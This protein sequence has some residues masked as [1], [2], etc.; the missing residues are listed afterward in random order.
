MY[1]EIIKIGCLVIQKKE[2]KLVVLFL[3]LLKLA[4][5]IM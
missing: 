2:L 5:L 4:K 1:A 3:T